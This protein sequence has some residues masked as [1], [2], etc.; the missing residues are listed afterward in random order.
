MIGVVGV[1][2]VA[3]PAGRVVQLDSLPEPPASRFLGFFV[4][5][6][7]QRRV[8]ETLE[9][10]HAIRGTRPDVPLG[11]A[12]PPDAAVLAALARLD[13]PID[14]DGVIAHRIYKGRADLAVR[15]RLERIVL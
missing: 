13:Y 8:L 2:A 7:T 9:W 3:Q 15:E 14:C 12:C 10:H 5:C 11:M 4:H 6:P 1:R